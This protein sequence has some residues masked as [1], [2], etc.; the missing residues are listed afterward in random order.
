[1]SWQQKTHYEL[2][3]DGDTTYGKCPA[4][5]RLFVVDGEHDEWHE[6]QPVMFNLPRLTTEDLKVLRSA[7]WL[8][9]DHG[10]RVLCPD[11]IEAGLYIANADLDGLSFA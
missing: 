10:E 6:G 5:W 8:V 2:R 9:V 7:K 4:V 11:H 1:M 3:C